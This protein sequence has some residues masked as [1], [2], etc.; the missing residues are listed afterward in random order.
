M[1]GG[2]LV[3]NRGED[4]WRAVD[5]VLWGWQLRVDWRMEI[6]VKCDET[7]KLDLPDLTRTVIVG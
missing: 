2:E 5:E 4:S 3:K 7:F 1:M 6:R